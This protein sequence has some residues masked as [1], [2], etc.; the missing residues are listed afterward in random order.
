MGVTIHYSGRF[1]PQASLTD[2]IDEVEDIAKMQGW[3]YH[4]FER[5]FP[6]TTAT[7]GVPQSHPISEN[8]DNLYGI[9]FSPPHC[10][11]VQFTF[12]GNGRMCSP[13]SLQCFGD[14]TDEEDQKYLYMLFT[15]TQF[16][17]TEIHKFIVGLLQ[18]LSRK[19]L[20]EF[21]VKDEGEYWETG[22]EALLKQKFEEVGTYI[23]VTQNMF[24]S[25]PM[26]ENE[27][28][29]EYTDRLMRYIGK[30]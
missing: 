3:E 19:Y 27:T 17:G 29:E 13:L 16:A 25:F 1:N 15:K 26:L 7:D 23:D 6:D 12:L 2:M 10:D 18:Y 21:K 22:D 30:R 24:E 20:L 8:N 5:E 4:V 9:L 28:I 11:P 14:S